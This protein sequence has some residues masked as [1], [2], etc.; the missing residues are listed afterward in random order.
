MV[1]TRKMKEQSKEQDMAAAAM[2]VGMQED[3]EILNIEN[4][5]VNDVDDTDDVDVLMK[6]SEFTSNYNTLKLLVDVHTT[7]MD[8]LEKLISDLLAIN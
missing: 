2:L 7:E 8:R 4:H 1:L 3:N 6:I 5:V